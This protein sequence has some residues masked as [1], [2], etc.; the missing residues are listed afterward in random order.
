MRVL[1]GMRPTGSLHLGHLVGALNNWIKLQAEHE[2]FFMVA[3]WHA[4]MSEYKH[5]EN[6]KKFSLDNI[7]DWISVGISPEKSCIFIQS[8]VPQHLELFMIF[9]VLTPLGWLYR[10]P[11]Y[12]DQLRELKEKD[13]A[14]YGFLGYPVLQ[15]SDIVLYKAQGVPVGEDQLPHLEL[16][17]EI[18]RR[19]HYIY[20]KEVFPEPQALLT[21]FPRL[22]GTDGRKMS[23]SFQNTILLKD[24]PSLIRKKVMSMFTDPTRIKKSQPGHPS[25]CN[26]FSY[27]KA[28]KP[29]LE[30]E[31]KNWCQGAKRG[32]TECKERLSQVIIEIL[33][34]FQERRSQL[35]N[36]K[37][38][39][40]DII[41]EGNKRAQRTAEETMQEVRKIYQ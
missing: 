39:V 31:V 15:A 29:S 38:L 8:Q 33:S 21:T 1:S 41:K 40:S 37:D 4:L 3:D 17:R 13:I 36:K 30:D 12:K 10:C 18:V 16:T 23:K 26:V 35:E 28:F 6:I 25:T 22:L 20:Q 14:N 27:Y 9:S 5:P 7:L 34:P 19:F 2:C 24:P 11:T 32:C